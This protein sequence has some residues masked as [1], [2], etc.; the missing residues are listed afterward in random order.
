[1]RVHPGLG[2]HL[3]VGVVGVVDRVAVGV[4]RLG[5][6]ADNIIRIRVDPAGRRGLGR[7][8]V[9]G[10]VGVAGHVAV[11]VGHAQQVA[12]AVVASASSCR[13]RRA[14]SRSARGPSRR[15]VMLVAWPRPSVTVRTLPLPS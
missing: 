15:S 3:V 9:R 10:R 11:G 5:Q 4:H 1:M 7:H 12:G 14:A 2:R 13:R 6:V 8:L